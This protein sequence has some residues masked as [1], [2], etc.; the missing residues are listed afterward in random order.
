MSKIIH[1]DMDQFYA[2][3]EQQDHPELR[4]KP[5]AVG[6]DAERGVVSTASYE[7]RRFG[8]HSAQSIQVAK[9]LCPQLII[10]EPHFQKYKEVSAQLHEIFHD[11]TDL[12]EP[13]SLDEAFLDVSENK[14]GIELGVDI[15]REIKQRIR[16]TT[17]LTA[18][19]GVSYCKFLAKIASDWRKPDGLTVIHPDRALDFIAQLKIEKIWG[20]GLKTAEKM[21]RM[22][23]FTGLDLRNMSLSRLTQEFGKMGQVFYDFSRGI[24][25]RPV[26][27]EWERKSVSCEQTF[28]SDINENAAV[29]IHLY[30]TVMELVRR[31]EKND[32]EG[33]TLTLKVKFAREREQTRHYAKFQD[34]QQITRSITVDHVLRT[35]DEILP[36]AKQLMQQVEFHSHPIRLLGLGVSNPGSPSSNGELASDHGAWCEL[37]LEFEPWPDSTE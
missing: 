12:I 6:H 29:T 18:S 5:I 36:L 27:S 26:I 24:D 30:H 37:E 9:R 1:V 16:E 11:Y 17:G 32:F 3:V 8:V 25:N 13:I 10:V 15:A 2:A 33:R 4:G 20:I 19:A 21:H 23:I 7:A 14:K 31:I 35:K 22:G 28:E 34:F